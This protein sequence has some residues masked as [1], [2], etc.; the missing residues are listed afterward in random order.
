MSPW[1]KSPWALFEILPFPL[2]AKC[3]IFKVVLWFK[4]RRGWGTSRVT[5]QLPNFLVVSGGWGPGW[6][7]EGTVR[8]V[9]SQLCHC[10]MCSQWNRSQQCQ[11]AGGASLRSLQAHAACEG[12]TGQRSRSHRK[13]RTESQLPG[14]EVQGGFL[15]SF[16]RLQ[17][18]LERRRGWGQRED[19]TWASRLP[20]SLWNHVAI[21][22]LS[23][24]AMPGPCPWVL[25]ACL[26]TPTT[27][28]VKWISS[29]PGHGRSLLP[30]CLA[31]G[32]PVVRLAVGGWWWRRADGPSSAAGWSSSTG[33]RPAASLGWGP[34]AGMAQEFQHPQELEG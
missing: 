16:P 3:N 34:V 24:K 22:G 8:R 19:A 18:S 1:L 26:T 31:T 17:E 13:W 2:K 12:C 15:G 27:L 20:A 6:G 28:S 30:L 10:S 23:E 33:R 5:A 25:L 29:A 11:G 4:N 9:I 21:M 7:W 32:R 14:Q